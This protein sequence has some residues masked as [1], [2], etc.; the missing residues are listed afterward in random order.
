MA[1]ELTT[2]PPQDG[3]LARLLVVA[4][5]GGAVPPNRNWLRSS[6]S[7]G[8]VTGDTEIS[9]G[10]GS[11]DRI[12]WHQS[13]QLRIF[14]N[15]SDSLSVA[16]AAGGE[17]AG[18]SI[19]LAFSDTDPA[20]R[21][22]VDG[23]SVTAVPS[24]LRLAADAA[25]EA[26]FNGVAVGDPINVVIADAPGADPVFDAVGDLEA[27]AP[28]SPPRPRPC[29]W[30]PRS[31]MSRR[32][33]PQGCPASRPRPWPWPA[34]RRFTTPRRTSWPG[35]RHHSRGRGGARRRSA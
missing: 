19:L 31:T 35:A 2:I 30:R 12:L 8:S 3:E 7:I 34:L 10:L 28:A 27:G 4:G 16:I 20:L 26:V 9:A 14:R 21:F 15:G 25:A 1:V 11:I 17:L 33:S 29:P 5:D 24:Y 13:I 6:A 23:A 18:K 22:D 32:T